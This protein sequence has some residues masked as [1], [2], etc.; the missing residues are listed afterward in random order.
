MLKSNDRDSLSYESGCIKAVAMTMSCSMRVD[1]CAV[2]G[3]KDS[4]SVLSTKVCYPVGTK[5]CSEALQRL[6]VLVC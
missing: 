6:E 3:V 5:Y 4:V 1:V 2:G